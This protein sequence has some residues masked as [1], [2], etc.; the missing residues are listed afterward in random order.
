MWFSFYAQKKSKTSDWKEILYI[1]QLLFGHIKNY[2]L[3]NMYFVDRF[4]AV[5]IHR[6]LLFKYC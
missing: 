3:N 5:L 4:C 2:F 1:L 6:Y